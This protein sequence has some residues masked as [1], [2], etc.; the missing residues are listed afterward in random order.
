MNFKL[1]YTH[2]IFNSQK[3]LVYKKPYTKVFYRPDYGNRVSIQRYNKN[4]SNMNF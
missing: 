4:D 1:L 2:I 3:F